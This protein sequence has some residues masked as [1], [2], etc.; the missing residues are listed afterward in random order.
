METLSQIQ[1]YLA[2]FIERLEDI[3]IM[4]SAELHGH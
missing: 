4:E 3:Y 1:L 2:W